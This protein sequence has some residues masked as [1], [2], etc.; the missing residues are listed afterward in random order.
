MFMAQHD[1]LGGQL[2]GRLMLSAEPFT[3]L[4]WPVEMRHSMPG[5]DHASMEP[6]M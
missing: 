2:T 1:V 5:M 6:G 4:I 3:T